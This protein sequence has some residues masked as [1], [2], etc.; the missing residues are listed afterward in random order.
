MA[1]N[2]FGPA[3]LVPGGPA[4]APRC[5]AADLS[6]A[7]APGIRKSRRMQPGSAHGL[8][9]K[10]SDADTLHHATDVS[11][12]Y[13]RTGR[14][15]TIC[16]VVRAMDSPI[17]IPSCL[18]AKEG[19]EQLR[20]PV[21][22]YAGAG[23]GDGDFHRSIVARSGWSGWLLFFCLPNHYL[24]SLPRIYSRMLRGGLEP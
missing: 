19:L 20:Q 8:E 16:T 14:Y 22:R 12:P 17:P 11:R 4:S 1:A 13:E 5:C 2:G 15:S 7:L 10:N 6:R 3:A 9:S 24:Q 21:N 18:V 23:V